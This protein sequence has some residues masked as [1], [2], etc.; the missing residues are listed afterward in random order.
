MFYS[1]TCG[2]PD[3]NKNKAALSPQ[4]NHFPYW[5]KMRHISVGVI[6]F[7]PIHFLSTKNCTSFSRYNSAF[8]RFAWTLRKINYCSTEENFY[9]VDHV[10]KVRI[11][12]N[13]T[14]IELFSKWREHLQSFT[15]LLIKVLLKVHLC[16]NIFIF[17]MWKLNYTSTGYYSTSLWKGPAPS[18]LV[19]K[20]S[21]FSRSCWNYVEEK[22]TLRHWKVNTYS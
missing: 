6:P 9:A 16:Q 18:Y 7:V 4:E 14:L 11:E 19:I 12:L 20:K 10:S 2:L 1:W 13:E 21:N 5:N 3:H 22:V 8:N 15:Q 17:W